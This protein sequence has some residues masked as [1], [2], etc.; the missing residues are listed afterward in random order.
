M[1][2]GD[3]ALSVI[4]IILAVITLVM[5]YFVLGEVFNLLRD[6]FGQMRSL[7]PNPGPET[8]RPRKPPETAVLTRREPPERRKIQ[9]YHDRRTVQRLIDYFE[10]EE[11]GGRRR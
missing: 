6:L 8:S 2:A 10:S 3:S 5:A 9:R 4:P 7:P 11:E 1:A